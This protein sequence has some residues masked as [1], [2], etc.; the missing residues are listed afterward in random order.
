MEEYIK[1]GS[2]KKRKEN[3]QDES[4]RTGKRTKLN[5]GFLG[6]C[7]IIVT[8]K[9][10]DIGERNKD[11]S[12]DL[13]NCLM[14]MGNMSIREIKTNK[15]VIAAI[16]QIF[17]RDHDYFKRLLNGEIKLEDFGTVMFPDIFLGQVPIV[18]DSDLFKSKYEKAIEKA[19]K[20]PCD[21]EFPLSKSASKLYTHKN[22][23][24]LIKDISGQLKGDLLE[25]RIY[26]DLQN[27][28]TQTKDACFILHGHSFLHGDNFKEKDFIIL[29]LTKGYVMSMEA[30]ASYK[31]F[32]SAKGQVQDCHKRIQAV[33]DCIEGMSSTWKFVGVCFF[34]DGDA[35]TIKNDFVINGTDDFNAKITKIESKVKQQN[36]RPEDHKKEFV[37][38]SKFLLFEAQGQSKGTLTRDKLAE[39]IDEDLNKASAPENIF[40]WTP[41]QLSIVQAMDEDWMFL[42]SFYGCGKTILLIERAQ[43]L[44]RNQ[45]N[46]VHFYIDNNFDINIQ[47]TYD[48]GLAEV[49][50]LKFEDKNI[51]IQSKRKIFGPDF[52]LS[53]DGVK[54]TDHV[55]IDEAYI[56][57]G[58]DDARAF[59][60]KLT[61]FQSQVSTLWVALG[62]LAFNS[63]EMHNFRKE[64]KRN[65]F[66]CPTLKYC[67]RNG[68]KIVELAKVSE[69][70]EGLNFFN[71]KV[72]VK[73]NVNDGLLY[74]LQHIYPTPNEA[75]RGA[76]QS[77]NTTSNLICI[78]DD[79]DCLRMSTLKEAFP[80]HDFNNFIAD[81]EVL[82]NWLDKRTTINQ[83][84]V[85]QDIN[86]YCSTV[87]GMEFQNMI[88]LTSICLKCGD[89]EKNISIITRAKA[90]LVIA[91]YER[92]NC[93][94]NNC[95]S[96]AYPN[97]KWREV[98][99]TWEIEGGITIDQLDEETR[100]F[101]DVI[102]KIRQLFQP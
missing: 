71:D 2:S 9:S 91:R 86:F 34:G 70:G 16:D 88:Y 72:E 10:Y 11:K 44:L 92:Q 74:K 49:L 78:N 35:S 45:N 52:D 47:D 5:L 84:L 43:Y 24:P 32:K 60:K 15:D 77:Q 54:P 63:V 6:V 98:C 56:D 48:S 51:R 57:Y 90:S 21:E 29:N 61:T 25:R 38:V 3:S 97:L 26:K 68:R 30:K 39:R 93:D 27:F 31:Q 55:I 46:T 85:L 62:H 8:H 95:A 23:V 89:E 14:D 81:K 69:D 50:K 75:L 64:L 102:S 18:P 37:S 22:G 53:S 19:D 67:L 28:F 33:F 76:L 1:P 83:H 80:D 94:I 41:E 59:L 58:I 12:R 96:L 100:E 17:E 79:Y 101:F 99:K 7:D 66:S 65:L 36:W 20:Y 73:S 82:K 4:E 13:L 42:M 40:F 87:S